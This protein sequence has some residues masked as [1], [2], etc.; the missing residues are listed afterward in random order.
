[1]KLRICSDLHLEY[2]DF[3]LPI[4]EDERNTVL[5]LAGDICNISR[6][7]QFV[8]FFHDVTSRF[9]KVLYVFGNHEFY[10]T[11]MGEA[12]EIFLNGVWNFFYNLIFTSEG[13]SFVLDDTT[14]I[15]ATLWTAWNH[16]QHIL[17]TSN[18]FSMEFC[19]KNMADFSIIK[20]KNGGIW[21][22]QASKIAHRNQLNF[23]RNAIE[24]NQTEKVVVITHHAPSLKS[25]HGRFWKHDMNPGFTSDL[26]PF[27]LK[28][29]PN[30]WIHGH[31][32]SSFDYL[33]NDKTRIICN[34]KG[35]GM[36]NLYFDPSLL[37]DL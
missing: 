12:E 32:H 27:I 7:K 6:H 28:Y 3:R 18:E 35:Y 9:R 37:I 23:I 31:T 33:D 26:S 34:P 15:M 36:E 14:F 13:I 11:T 17:N 8:S 20:D 24:A 1:M 4:T 29:K 16:P 22:P 19:R 10:R 2:E 25:I 30:L 21:T 5:V